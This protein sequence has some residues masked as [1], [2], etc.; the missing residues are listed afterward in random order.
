M[1]AAAHAREHYLEWASSD[2]AAGLFEGFRAPRWII[3]GFLPVPFA[4]MALRFL[5]F[6]VR[7]PEPN[8]DEDAG[9]EAAP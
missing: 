4:V 6:G 9:G 2:G 5:A 1:L 8:V 3:F 7:K